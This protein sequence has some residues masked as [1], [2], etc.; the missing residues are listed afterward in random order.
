M[1]KSLVALVLA[2]VMMMTCVS[3]LAVEGPNQD[4]SIFPLTDE[5]ITV[6]MM[7]AYTDVMPSDW[8]TVWFWQQLEELTNVHIEFIPVPSSDRAT[9]LNLRLASADLPDILFK[10]AVSSTQAAQYGGEGLLIDLNQ[11][12][13]VMPNFNYWLDAYPTARNAVTQADGNIY[14]CPYILTGYAI[15]MGSRFFFNSQVLEHAGY[16]TPP[17]TLDE[18][19]DYLTKIKGWDYNENGEDDT[20]PLALSEWEDLEYILTGSFGVMN[21][22]SSNYWADQAEDGKA[23]FW[24]TADG[25]KELMRYYNKLYSEGLVDPDIFTATFADEIA[26]AQNGRALTYVFVNNSPVSG[27]KYE[28]Y[29]VPMTEPLAGYDGTK[30]WNAFSMPASTSSNFC[31]TAKCPEEYRE[32]MAKW[33]DYF[34]S[35]E[36][37]VAYFMGEEGESY[38][39]D[40]ATDTYALT[41]KILKDPEGRNFEAVQSAWCTW[42][43]SMNPSC[44][45]NELFKGGETWPVSLESAAGLIN[46]TPDKQEG[47]AVWAPFL[48]DSEVA[49]DVSAMTTDFDTYL[50]EWAAKFITGEKNVDSDWEEYVNGFNALGVQDYLDLINEK[51]EALGL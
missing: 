6:T 5:K 48:F 11:Y 14:G 37:I 17:A 20:L 50:G 42:A 44:A 24:H 25:Y 1:K 49:S 4:M 3:A 29:T 9:T 13:D 10:M 16:A 35:I 41:D 45:T 46:Y 18:F 2:I 32:I 21:R 26:K 15:R 27:S 38:T 28:Q 51:I 34:Y 30:A 33:A 31:I 43:G 22:G 19:Y 36:G 8:S 23:R 12:K 47:G 39:Y 40:A 7:H